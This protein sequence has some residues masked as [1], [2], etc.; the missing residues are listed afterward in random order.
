MKR[1]DL[2]KVEF[3]NKHD[4]FV[5]GYFHQWVLV[6]SDYGFETYV[7]AIIEDEKGFVRLVSAAAIKFI[8]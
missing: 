8:D 5:Q 7:K 6:K 2:R 3:K 4:E 1:E